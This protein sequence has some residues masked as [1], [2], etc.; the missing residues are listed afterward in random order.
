MRR[1]MNGELRRPTLRTGRGERLA[2]ANLALLESLRRLGAQTPAAS[3]ARLAHLQSSIRP[4]FLFNTLNSAIALVRAEPR[5]AEDVLQDLSE[6]FREALADSAAAVTLSE[7]LRLAQHYL[8]IEKIRFGARLCV[9]WSLDPLAGAARL[10]RL[11][12]QPLVENAVTHGV[13]PSNAGATVLIS[14]ERK[15][16]RAVVKVSNTCPAGAGR[17]GQGIA[18][19]NVRER[20][21]L[22]HGTDAQ[23][24][25]VMEGDVFMVRLELPL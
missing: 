22:L 13:E 17:P 16:G 14:T 7:E 4:H 8:D 23:F 3:A 9:D 25:A 2:H 6:L 15:Q 21:R 20:L 5:K 18:L 1:L 11:L 19:A 10:P 24:K 12:L